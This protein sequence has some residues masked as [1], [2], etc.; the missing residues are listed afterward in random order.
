MD[1]KKQTGG[2]QSEGTGER[3]IVEKPKG[4]VIVQSEPL[5]RR[6]TV[7]KQK[8]PEMLP[9]HAH[10]YTGPDNTSHFGFKKTLTV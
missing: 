5:K 3:I 6:L 10:I 4:S 2:S 1:Y 8:C 9:L 7:K